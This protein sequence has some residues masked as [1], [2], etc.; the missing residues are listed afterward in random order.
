MAGFGILLTGGTGKTGSRIAAGLAAQGVQARVASRDVKAARPQAVHFEWENHATHGPALDGVGAVYLVAPAGVADPLEAMTPFLHAALN[1]GV[2]RYVL[3]SASSLPEGGPMMGQ[4]HA[5]LHSN[6]PEWVVL[7]P[8]W[9]MQNFSEQQHLPTIRDEGAIYTAAGD[10]QV[11]FI[12]ADD[13]AAVGVAALLG[14]VPGD[15]DRILTGPRALSY[16]EAASIIAAAAGRP[17]HHQRLSEDELARRLAGHGLPP[18]YAAALAAMDTA[19]AGCS[20]DR[21]TD[22]VK[23][24]TGRE[25]I[26]FEAFAAANHDRWKAG[27]R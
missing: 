14:K 18:A 15:G 12:H 27:A 25:P 10:G 20:E 19:I 11:P 4:V 26:S 8:A 17:V 9:F 16:D 7:R 6:A 13:I 22:A 2:R 1:A 5:F 21:V 23:A 3:L 24:V